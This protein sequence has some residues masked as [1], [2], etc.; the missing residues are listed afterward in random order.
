M[1]VLDSPRFSSLIF[2][3]VSVVF[4]DRALG[5]WRFCRFILYAVLTKGLVLVCEFMAI[6]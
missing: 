4:V 5:V 1:G 6:M 3:V 2:Y